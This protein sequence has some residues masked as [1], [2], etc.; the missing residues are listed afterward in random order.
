MHNDLN[1]DDSHL[2]YGEVLTVVR[3]ILGQL[4]QKV[5]VNDMIAPVNAH[6]FLQSQSKRAPLIELPGPALLTE[7]TAPTCHRGI[8]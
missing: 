6:P 1:A 7:Q 3:I 4:K 5:F 8:L 2:L